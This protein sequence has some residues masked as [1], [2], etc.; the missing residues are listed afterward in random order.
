MLARELN[1]TKT[2]PNSAM[3]KEINNTRVAKRGAA[4]EREINHNISVLANPNFV[5]KKEINNAREAKRGA[6]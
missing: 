4:L 6:M 3:K 5:M 1:I 2:N